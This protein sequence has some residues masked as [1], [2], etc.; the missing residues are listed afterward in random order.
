MGRE[1]SKI[2]SQEPNKCLQHRHQSLE[3]RI[4]LK[5][6][7]SKYM[8]SLPGGNRGNYPLKVRSQFS[9]TE[10]TAVASTEESVH[11]ETGNSINS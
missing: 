10:A 8:E 3:I 11:P 6:Q 7:L 5:N 9:E 4:Q 1:D 2:C